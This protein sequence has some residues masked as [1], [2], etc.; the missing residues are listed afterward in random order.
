[1]LLKTPLNRAE[2]EKWSLLKMSLGE[3]EKKESI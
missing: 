1:M 2:K 3:R